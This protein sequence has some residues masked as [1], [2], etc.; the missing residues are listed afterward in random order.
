MEKFDDAVMVWLKLSNVSEGWR[1]KREKIINRYLSPFFGKM[2][3]RDIDLSQINKFLIY[4]KDNHNLSPKTTKNIL[5]EVRTFL[6]Y[7]KDMGAIKATPE[8]KKI[9]KSIKPQKSAIRWLDE[10]SQSQVFEF[11]PKRHE[12]I[13]R[14]LKWT[15]ARPSEACGLQK[16]SI[17]GDHCQLIIAN[18][19]GFKRTLKTTKT[20]R[21]RC[22]PIL[23][24]FEDVLKPQDTTSDFVFTF[25]QGK[26][27]T[28]GRLRKIWTKASR[29]AH[30]KYHTPIIPFYCGT[31][32]SFAMTR[33]NGG[34]PLAG[35]SAI[36]GHSSPQ[37]TVSH[38]ARFLT[39][40]MIPIM[41]GKPEESERIIR[42]SESRF[43]RPVSYRL[44]TPQS[45]TNS[46]PAVVIQ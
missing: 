34:F 3:V 11:L 40:A 25:G 18:S 33:L 35:I 30:A 43:Q 39:D 24:E 29:K 44:T 19:L 32:H 14:F 28:T 20:H 16:S 15:G 1:Y 27:Y 41:K 10:T 23:R 7:E 12:G 36:L 17:F 13:F 21:I 6:F 8:F 38:Y 46:E 5:S 45:S 22:L 9:F 42:T 2:R 26:I 4:L 37:T 31:R